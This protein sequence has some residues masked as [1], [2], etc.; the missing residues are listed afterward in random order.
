MIV[1][2]IVC[3]FI[4]QVEAIGLQHF[5]KLLFGYDRSYSVFEAVDPNRKPKVHLHLACGFVGSQQPDIFVHPAA[6]C[7]T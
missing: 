3:L 7:G 5:C 2:M 4:V 6:L 1:L